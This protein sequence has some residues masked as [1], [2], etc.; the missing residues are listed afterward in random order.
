MRKIIASLHTSLDGYVGGP[1]GEMDWIELDDVMFELVGEFTREADGALY[2]RVTYD[3]MKAYWPTAADQPNATPHDIEHSAW[4]NSVQK[5]VLS[6]SMDG[7]E[8][9][10]TTFIGTHVPEAIERVK[11]EEGKNI[12]VFGSPS[13]LHFL[14]EHNLIDEYWLFVNP[15]LLGT[16]I[17]LF[18]KSSQR[19]KLQHLRTESL[20]NGVTALNYAVTGK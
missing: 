1:H 10:N 9:D 6:R 16:G 13:A 14:M 2:G 15:V 19:V 11:N 3:M 4:Y 18:A 12:M 8:T 17:P 5:I 7:L 20:P